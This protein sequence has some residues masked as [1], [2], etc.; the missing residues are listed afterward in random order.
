MK[1]KW[2]LLLLMFP[3]QIRIL[4]RWFLW[5]EEKP[6]YPEKTSKTRAINE[7]LKFDLFIY[8]LFIYLSIYHLFIYFSIYL[9]IYLFI[10]AFK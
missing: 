6:E 1:S 5:R 3:D 4:R 9:L 10:V 8:Y 2:W 7:L